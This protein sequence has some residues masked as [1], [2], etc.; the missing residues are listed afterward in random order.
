MKLKRLAKILDTTG[1]RG[2]LAGCLRTRG[3]VGLN[4]HRIGHGSN[5][6]LDRELWSASEEQFDQQLDFLKKN[7]DVISPDDIDDARRDRRGLHVLITFDDGYADNYE[8]AFPTLKRHAVPATFFIATGYIDNPRLPWWDEISA[9]IRQT[10]H[11]SLNLP[12]WLPDPLVIRPDCRR[13]AIRTL[14]N[15]YK[16]LPADQAAA[17]LARLREVSAAPAYPDSGKLWMTWDM[18]RQMAADG[19]TIG[20][21]SVNH[22][23][24]SSV[25]PE[26][27]WQEISGCARRI[28]EELGVPMRYFA[29]PVG[30]R[31]TFNADTQECLERLG[32]RYA[33]SYYGGFAM[34]GSSRFDMRRVAIEPY[35][36][37]CWFRSIVQVP[38]LF[39]RLV[40]TS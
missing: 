37:Q 10:P 17:L 32:V 7:C 16:K 15:V 1:L 8:L 6:V 31:L 22:V 9:L 27:Q 33:F 24:L 39:C 26:A 19:M 25:S 28:E 40:E 29:Y 30:G 20:G 18:I 36:D 3:I 4:Y 14:L 23:I 13:T 11:A 2:V 12:D 34:E 35:I 5:S 38:R 21:H